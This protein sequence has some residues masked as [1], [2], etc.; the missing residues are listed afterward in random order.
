MVAGRRRSPIQS[1]VYSRVV[2]TEAELFSSEEGSVMVAKKSVIIV[3]TAGN[4]RNDRTVS[5]YY[6]LSSLRGKDTEQSKQRRKRTHV[7]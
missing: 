3:Y 1:V 6:S 2:L 5:V 4:K 7:A